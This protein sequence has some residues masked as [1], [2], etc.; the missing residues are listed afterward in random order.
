MFKQ[1]PVEPILTRYVHIWTPEV[2]SYV[3]DIICRNTEVWGK[4]WEV[5]KG[6]PENS[7]ARIRWGSQKAHPRTPY[8][9]TDI[10]QGS[11]WVGKR[12]KMDGDRPE[13]E[14]ES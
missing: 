10:H 5:H 6:L 9:P 14:I 11:R 2:Y 3:V 13:A 1:V 4:E 12:N 8:I 7:R